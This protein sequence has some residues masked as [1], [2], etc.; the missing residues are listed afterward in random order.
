MEFQM[1]IAKTICARYKG[2]DGWHIFDSDE[3]PGLFVASRDPSA[4]F[5]DLAPAIEMLFRLDEGIACKAIPEATLEEFLE[6]LKGQTHVEE[7]AKAPV[8][9]DKRF[10]VSGLAIA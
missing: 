4:A 7:P 6:A 3:L 8:M 2:V 1:T 10:I 5:N 9:E